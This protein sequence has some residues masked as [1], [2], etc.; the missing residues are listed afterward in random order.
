VALQ[1]VDERACGLLRELLRPAV[2]QLERALLGVDAA[3]IRDRAN[4]DELFRRDEVGQRARDWVVVTA[5]AA[6]GEVAVLAV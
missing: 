5:R 2:E 6:V 4:G 1:L 3:R